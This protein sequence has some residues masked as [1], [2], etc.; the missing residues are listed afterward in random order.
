MAISEF[1]K[2][3]NIE[4]VNFSSDQ[5]QGTLDLYKKTFGHK[6]YSPYIR[7]LETQAEDV[8]R[9]RFP[10]N[11][12]LRLLAIRN[13]EVIGHLG[14]WAR[15]IDVFGSQV[16]GAELI[17]GLVDSMFR[18]GLALYLLIQKMQEELQNRGVQFAFLFPNQFSEMVTLKRSLINRDVPLLEKSLSDKEG[19][20]GVSLSKDWTDFS[21]KASEIFR[22]CLGSSVIATQRTPEYF[23]WRYAENPYEIYHPIIL[24][25]GRAYAVVKIY[26]GERAH[27]VDLVSEGEDSLKTIMKQAEEL[28]VAKGSKSISL[29]PLCEPW[30]TWVKG[31][32]YQSKSWRK[33][34]VL[35]RK[36]ENLPVKD[37]DKWYLNMC[38][39][40][41]F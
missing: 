15:E 6:T 3:S 9:W 34:A 33:M 8:W 39:H 1:L 21:Q 2:R 31:F 22:R 27:I 18:N 14:A 32:G 41:I 30:A 23:L 13:G 12:S 36:S 37:I 35:G 7:A 38:E 4:I 40:S 24:S 29:Y 5:E 17:E 11:N 25:E 26:N 10:D 19:K 20:Q 16:Q 28:A